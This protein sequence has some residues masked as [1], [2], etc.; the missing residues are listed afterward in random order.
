[1]TLVV[2]HAEPDICFMVG[3]TLLSHE[4][5][6]LKGDIG[7]VNGE[8][9]SL[10]IQILTGDLAIGFANNFDAA[11]S[12]IAALKLALS[13][14]PT[15]DPAKWLAAKNITDSDFLVLKNGKKE[16]WVI[17]NGKVRQAT[18]AHIGDSNEWN[19]LL[20]LKREYKGAP[21]RTSGEKEFSVVSDAME[22]LC[23]D[24]VGRK[25]PTVGAISGC[26]VR[27]VD[28]RISGQLEYLQTVEAS[29]FPWEPPGGFTILA[30]NEPERGI[31][32]YFRVGRRGFILPVVGQSPCV[33][34]AAPTLSAFIE[35][36]RRKF[37][38]RLTGGA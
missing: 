17:E 11:Y 29:H 21:G 10:K 31:G 9:H 12:A 1:M 25:E 34:S 26:V 33:A 22:A 5:F 20:Q 6:A 30:S 32:I 16:L 2:A 13:D 14:D 36:A 24:C 7:P 28:A 38:M 37:G 18:N 4:H 3:D 19:R 35:E 8:F 23:W 27:V 15:L